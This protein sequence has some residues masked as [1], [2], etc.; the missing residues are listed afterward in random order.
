MD[1]DEKYRKR[2]EENRFKQLELES[3]SERLSRLRLFIFLGGFA[4]T[5]FAFSTYDEKVYGAVLAV[6]SLAVFIFLVI[7]HEEV[8]NEA[9]R[10]RNMVE[11]NEKCILRMEGSWEDFSDDGAEYVNP[12][13][14]YTNDLDIFGHA[15]LFQWIN[16]AK[17][18]S[19]RETLRALLENPEKDISSIRQRQDAVKELSSKLDFCQRLQCEGM[20]DDKLRNDPEDILG[21]AESRSKFFSKRWLKWVFFVLPGLTILSF[22]VWYF[23]RSNF[24][25]APL[26][27]LSLQAIII[28]LG[29]KKIN[30]V[31]ETV[32]SYKTKVAVYQRLLEVIEKEEFHDSYLRSLQST[33]FH[34]SETASQDIKRLDS[35]A[36]AVGLRYNALV[37]FVFNI[38]LLWDFHCALALE[39]WQE[40]SG[41][42]LRLWLNTIGCMEALSSLAL[43][44]QLNPKWAFPDFSE[45]MTL[46]AAEELGH[47]LISN[48]KRVANDFVINNQISIV[49]GSNMSGKTTFLRTIGIN[50]VLAYAGA[51]VCAKK[52]KCSL[53]DIFTSM[54]IEDDL[55]GGISTFYAELLRIRMIIENSKKEKAMIY[56]IDEVF[57]GTNSTDRVIGARNVLLNL[58]KTWIIGLISTHDFE[59]CNLEKEN[60]SRVKN[61]HFMETYTDNK[62]NFDYKIRPGRCTTTNAQF[63]MKMV[64]IEIMD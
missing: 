8:I 15:S 19:G 60:N 58:D 5:A 48:Q 29:Y 7:K 61:Y 49:T 6:V 25:Y 52:L 24:F 53:M 54:R 51:P 14:N 23:G 63:L 18:Y 36:G 59:L 39:N 35:I 31:L 56:L 64:G 34:G 32:Y 12:N 27:L 4:L 62:I 33:L 40:K 55:H 17:S 30:D 28:L 20:G 38:I 11:I 1:V 21:Y 26:L 16:T 10:Y 43:I 57:R 46:L 45:E 13:H 47:P 42:S 2:V 37:H 3:N 9:K 44:S 50:L 41:I 22:F